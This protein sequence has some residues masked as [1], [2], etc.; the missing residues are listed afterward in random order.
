M[1]CWVVPSVAAEL[2]GC[3]VE[4]IMSAIRDGRLCSREENGW[5]FVDMMPDSPQIQMPQSVRPPTYEVVSAEE[6]AALAIATDKP[7]DERGEPE[8]T[9]ENPESF[10]M[11]TS[12]WR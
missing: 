12:R 6:A 9:L 4:S 8:P 10:L 1:S 11:S 5:T 2:W 7:C 3:S